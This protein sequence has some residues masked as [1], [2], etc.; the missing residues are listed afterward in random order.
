MLVYVVAMLLSLYG[1]YTMFEYYRT[2]VGFLRV[3]DVMI[4]L[5][6]VGL[7]FTLN[8][9]LVVA[10]FTVM[11]HGP[12]WISAIFRFVFG[13]MNSV[14]YNFEKPKKIEPYV[15]PDDVW[16]DGVVNVNWEDVYPSLTM[17]KDNV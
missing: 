4:M 14:V 11:I 5:L 13:N 9:N 15:I 16:S 7:S 6:L 1:V 3:I 12:S 10:A 2:V 17:E 8:A